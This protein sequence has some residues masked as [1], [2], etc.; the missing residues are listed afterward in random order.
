MCG[1]LVR[2]DIYGKFPGALAAQDLRKDF[3]GVAHEADGQG[4]LVFLG[5]QD[6]LQGLVEVGDNLI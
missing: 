2:D 3:S 5:I 4:F 6:Q 1:G